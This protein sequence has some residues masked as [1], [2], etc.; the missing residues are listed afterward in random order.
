MVSLREDPA[1]IAQRRRL[2]PF[3]AR[4]RQASLGRAPRT[5]NTA[6]AFV[7]I[8]FE[9][10]LLGMMLTHQ[11]KHPSSRVSLSEKGFRCFAS[12]PAPRSIPV[13]LYPGASERT[14]D[15]RSVARPLAIPVRPAGPRADVWAGG[16]VG[17]DK[18][19]ASVCPT[20]PFVHPLG[21]RRVPDVRPYA[22]IDSGQRSGNGQCGQRL[23]QPSQR[24]ERNLQA[25]RG[26]ESFQLKRL[27]GPPPAL[28]S[29]GSQVRVLPGA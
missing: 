13:W 29:R 25:I 20:R 22:L 7:R 24:A 5:D 9:P 21:V 2:Q 8:L 16:W 3:R 1:I 26:P 23:R 27:G 18:P 10:R 14:N 17:A 6:P 19:A 15:R 28:L 11:L 12:L 4:G